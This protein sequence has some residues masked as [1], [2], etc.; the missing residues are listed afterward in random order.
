MQ[1]LK[2]HTV[3]LKLKAVKAY[4]KGEGSYRDISRKFGIS[5]HDI[6]RDR[7]LWYNVATAA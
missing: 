5:H 7:V 3:E 2:K 6:L 4:L 1:K